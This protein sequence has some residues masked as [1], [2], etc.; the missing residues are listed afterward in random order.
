MLFGF[1]LFRA[2]DKNR[3]YEKSEKSL[4]DMLPYSYHYDDTT[5]MTKNNEFISVIKLLG[6]SFETA[7]DEDVDSKKSLRNNLFKGM[8]GNGLS[9]YFH[10]VRKK[11]SAF[12]K[13]D[14]DNI[15]TEKLN[16]A[17]K[18]R[19][20]PEHT[21]I[22]EHY[23]TII[24]KGPAKTTTVLKN[25][26]E[27]IKGSSSG[28]SSDEKL[29]KEA[30]ADITEV[31]DRLLNGLNYYKPHLLSIRRDQNGNF[32]EICEFLS[33][34]VNLGFE[35][36]MLVPRGNLSKYL[37]TQRVYF[38]QKAIEVFG[39]TYHKYAGIVSLKE[40]RPATYSGI[41]DNFLK[42]PCEFIITQSYEFIDRMVAISKM[43]LQQRRLMQAEDVAISQVAEI[44]SALDSA[45]SGTFAFGMHHL[46][47][48]CIAD[49]LKILDN[50]LS[51]AIVE[52]ANVGIMAVRES[53]N[54][55]A[56]FWAQLPGNSH[57]A[58]RKSTINTLNLAGYASLH[59]YPSGKIESNHWGNA[60][61]V[62]N[63]TS[64]TPYFFNFHARD[65]GHT[66]IIGPTGGGKTMLLNFLA[67]QAQK[68]NP[69]LFFFDKDRGAELFIRAINGKH[70][71]INPGAQ[72]NFNPFF[73]NDTPENRNFLIE[74][75]KIL[76][77]TNGEIVTAED[78]SK[79]NA[80]VDG[81]YKLPKH[82]RKLRNLAPFLGLEIGDSMA[83]RLKMWHSDGS[84][85]KIFDNDSDMIDFSDGKTFAFDMAEILKD[86]VA[87]T[88]VLLYIFHKIN[89]SLDGTPT[90]IILDEA[91][92][93]ID[94]PIF[95]PKI[96]DW[97]KVMRKL[98]AFVVFATQS[99]EDAAKSQISDTLIQQTATQIFLP[100]L[101]A[102]S[103]YMST[104][105]LSKR[106]YSLIKTADPSS[107]FFLIKQDIDGVIARVNLTGMN[108]M[109][110]ILSGRMDLVLMANE[111]IKEYGNDPE[112]WLPIFFERI[113]QGLNSDKK[114]A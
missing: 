71:I 17:W 59:N 39:P 44:D 28:E 1:K 65:V 41:L 35:Q 10:T 100:N 66:M 7:D 11:Y 78:V 57:Y 70:T 89:L 4:S 38:S 101:K 75:L 27:K 97:L 106:E 96:R 9:L 14:F 95:A 22:N 20:K 19:H 49:D 26:L 82:Q 8:A 105:M 21:F 40:Y 16:K 92:A 68:F 83:V 30:Y 110:N 85:A 2:E 61:T 56:C 86:K 29:L 90:M 72:C 52:F 12:P 5:I 112:K 47:I 6:F 69:R 58:V 51:Q 91:W 33:K 3:T 42:M 43:Q 46:T 23:I 31:K 54:M 84:K 111:I 74:W 81:L 36:K 32:S 24:K 77:S 107:R 114:V 18:E 13:G 53:I 76:L 48:L 50:Y 67:A 34:I 99:V 104:F 64:G 73:L 109:I 88:P 103:V 93:L 80:A 108:D 55:E 37:S 98:N 94:N 60:V 113:K 25:I 62:M 15:F 63:T 79:L 87:L 102:T 45:M